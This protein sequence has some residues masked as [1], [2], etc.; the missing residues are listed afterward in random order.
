MRECDASLIASVTCEALLL[1]VDTS[2]KPGLV[3][4][5]SNGSHK[6]LNPWLFYQ[7]ALALEPYFH[8]FARLGASWKGKDSESLFRDV[9][10][11][12]KEAEA[13]MFKATGGINTHKGALFS[14]GILDTAWGYAQCQGIASAD[15]VCMLASHM[16]S[17][18][19][20]RELSAL[21][22]SLPRSNGER[23]LHRYGVRGIRAE[24]MEGFPSVRRYGLS[25][26]RSRGG[27][28]DNH[29]RL[30]ALVGLMAHVEDS[31]LLHRGG[32]EGL[33]FVRQA[34][35]EISP[36]RCLEDQLAALDGPFVSRNL[37]SGGAAD[38]LSVSMVCSR[39]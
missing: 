37:S 17:K 39:I 5:L 19:L 3:D 29:A 25:P 9:R 14:L 11:I 12:G 35:R 28:R 34:M 32:W 27:W 4:L 23:V 15:T 26:L 24:V 8:D 18:S 22:R 1:E 16:T 10:E 2:P 6:D 38:L 30:S 33:R 21:G 20:G 7:S 13:A 31:N 36:E